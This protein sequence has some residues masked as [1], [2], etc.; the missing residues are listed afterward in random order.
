MV[1]IWPVS[2][3]W[4][5]G[6][7]CAAGLDKADRSANARNPNF[8]SAAAA[9]TDKDYHFGAVKTFPIIHIHGSIYRNFVLKSNTSWS[10][11]VQVLNL[12]VG[13]IWC[14]CRYQ[15]CDGNCV[16]VMLWQQQVT[17]VFVLIPIHIISNF[18]IYL[19]VFCFYLHLHVY[20]YLNLSNKNC[21]D[22]NTVVAAAV[23]WWT[24]GSALTQSQRKKRPVWSNHT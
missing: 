22:V 18:I 3:Q 5:V 21:V 1:D 4:G 17:F 13:T 12:N 2:R 24:R 11:L 19:F 14:R 10:V 23:W 9:V 6:S 7:R 8:I 16:L 15:L 20:L